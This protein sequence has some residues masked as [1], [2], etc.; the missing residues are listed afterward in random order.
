[1]NN[2]QMAEPHIVEAIRIEPRFAPAHVAMGNILL[3]KGDPHS[4]QEQ[5]KE[6]LKLDPSGMFA[7]GVRSILDKMKTTNPSGTLPQEI[8]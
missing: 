7:A 2:W 8:H 4:A 3:K 5:Y 6:Y 1:M